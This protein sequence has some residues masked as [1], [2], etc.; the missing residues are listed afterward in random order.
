MTLRHQKRGAARLNRTNTIRYQHTRT[1]ATAHPLPTSQSRV[2]VECTKVLSWQSDW[3]Q[4]VAEAVNF[5]IPLNTRAY[6]VALQ[7]RV[8]D[9]CRTR[10]LQCVPSTSFTRTRREPS[11]LQ[12]FALRQ[13]AHKCRRVF[14]SFGA[15]ASCCRA[16]TAKQNAAKQ[17]KESR[18]SGPDCRCTR[19]H[20]SDDNQ[21]LGCCARLAEAW[22]SLQEVPTCCGEFRTQLLPQVKAPSQ[23][24]LSKTTPFWW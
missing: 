4:Q 12:L 23:F 24:W 6:Q 20:S 22:S 16:E 11:S 14:V 10:F 8:A 7:L 1:V 5:V 17:E 15:L 19:R 13:V 3:L 2:D 9:L 21:A 18:G